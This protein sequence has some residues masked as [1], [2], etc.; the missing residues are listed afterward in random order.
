MKPG[1]LLSA[2]VN[3]AMLIFGPFIVSGQTATGSVDV[4]LYGGGKFTCISNPFYRSNNTYAALFNHL[5]AGTS[6]QKWNPNIADFDVVLKTSF[7]IGWSPTSGATNTLNP[8][9]GLF[10][11]LQGPNITNTFSG[12]V[13]QGWLTNSMVPGYNLVGNMAP[14]S[15]LNN[16]LSLFPPTGS[17]VQKWNVELQDFDVYHGTTFGP[18]WS[19]TRPYIA[20]GEGFFIDALV[21]FN[22]V[23]NYTVP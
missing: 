23:R 21:A 5:P 19:P 14:D 1:M 13:L 6:L 9:E 20:A 11:C 17:A 16:A 12:E 10:V 8:G 18:G 15:G 3:V 2:L 4:V 7:G 22:W